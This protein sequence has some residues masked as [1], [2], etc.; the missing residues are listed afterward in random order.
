MRRISRLKQSA[1]GLVNALGRSQAQ[2][3]FVRGGKRC[4]LT[5]SDV[6]WIQISAAA[7]NVICCPFSAEYKVAVFLLSPFGD[8]QTV[9]IVFGLF[10]FPLQEPELQ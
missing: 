2:N 7:E 10:I 4:F 3:K 8:H 1:S 9:I 6:K 5:V